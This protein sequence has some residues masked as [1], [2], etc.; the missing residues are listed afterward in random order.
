MRR[1]H[2]LL[3]FFVLIPV[4]AVAQQ[5]SVTADAPAIRVTGEATSSSNPDLL[6]LQIAIVT[7]DSSAQRASADNATV[8]ANVLQTL[9]TVLGTGSSVT[10]VDYS[11]G[12]DYVRLRESGE[13]RQAG[14][15]VR[16]VLRVETADLNKAGQLVDAAVAAGANEIGV[17]Q[18]TLRELSK[19]EQ[20]AM[21]AAAQDARAKAQVL[22]TAMGVKLGGVRL[23]ENGPSYGLPVQI[24]G[25]RAN[26][27]DAQ[28]EILSGPVRVHS[29]VTVT[30]DI[31]R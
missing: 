28:T 9:R 25:G 17:I 27:A 14:H 18:Y 26:P 11:L 6:Q 3:L 20:T 16:N 2:P 29:T 19:L 21:G 4:A 10:T 1:L 13:M 7:R 12:P 22:A 24:R 8:V 15:V 5:V 31:A 30:F 23:V